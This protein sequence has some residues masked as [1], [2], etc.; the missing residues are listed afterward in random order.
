MARKATVTRRKIPVLVAL[1]KIRAAKPRTHKD[2][3]DLGLPLRW[4]GTGA[5]RECCEILNCDLVVKFP[6]ARKKYASGRRHTAM[7]MA[8]L[9]RLRQHRVMHP[10]LPEV[11]YY[12]K[13]HGIIVM[14]KY[15]KYESFEDQADAMGQMIQ[16]LIYAVTKVR[17]QDIHTENVRKRRMNH[18]QST[19][20]DLGY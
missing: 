14:R 12:D 4:V 15:P 10:N 16:R 13:K 3:K 5:F 20:I 7:E 8:R 1:K 18:D 17:C 9:K 2:F 11:F 19:L 6:L